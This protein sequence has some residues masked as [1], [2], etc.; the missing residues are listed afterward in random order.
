MKKVILIGVLVGLLTGCS[1]GTVVSKQEGKSFGDKP[2]IVYQVNGKPVE[3]IE[4]IKKLSCNW[5]K[6]NKLFEGGISQ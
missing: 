6:H 4:R 3:C 2:L 5:E 1:D